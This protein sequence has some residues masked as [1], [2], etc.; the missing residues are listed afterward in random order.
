[1]ALAVPPGL[2]PSFPG[3][4]AGLIAFQTGFSYL[5]FNVFCSWVAFHLLSG[6]TLSLPLQTLQLP[7][8][9]CTGNADGWE[10]KS[11]TFLST[12]VTVRNASEISD[13]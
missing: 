10:Q 8:D 3:L 2:I 1:M 7:V 4:P 13:L 11:A 5:L 9:L 12:L 6:L